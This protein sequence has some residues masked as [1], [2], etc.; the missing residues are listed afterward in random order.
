MLIGNA[1]RSSSD[2]GDHETPSI[3]PEMANSRTLREV[4]GVDT[5]ALAHDSFAMYAKFIARQGTSKENE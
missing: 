2:G 5:N 4:V 1:S 3:L